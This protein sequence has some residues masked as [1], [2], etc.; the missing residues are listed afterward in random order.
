MKLQDYIKNKPILETQQLTLRPLR[1]EDVADL[2]EWLG[3]SS[4]YQF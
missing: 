1:Q 2:K 4:I 3:N